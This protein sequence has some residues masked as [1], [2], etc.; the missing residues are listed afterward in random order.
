[1]SSSHKFSQWINR[2]AVAILFFSLTACG[3]NNT[4]ARINLPATVIV[5]V[6][7]PAATENRVIDPTCRR[8]EVE[9]WVQNS[10]IGIDDLYNLINTAI[11]TPPDK[12]TG[13]ITK[14]NQAYALII[15]TKVPACAENQATLINVL[16]PAVISSF[17]DYASGKPVDLPKLIGDFNTQIKAIKAL[18]QDLR[19][20]YPTLG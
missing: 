20:R 2:S 18:E 19:A 6:V 11:A 17:N 5:P 3:G 15:N 14:M 7:T 10:G 12:M 13:L 9:L 1:M 16:V 4:P 8:D